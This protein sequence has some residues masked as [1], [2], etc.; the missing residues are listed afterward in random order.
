MKV[1]SI[2]SCYLRARAKAFLLAAS[3]I[4]YMVLRLFVDAN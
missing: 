3:V 4:G 1:H 2:K